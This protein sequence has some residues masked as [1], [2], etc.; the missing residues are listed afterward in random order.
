MNAV[1]S[2]FSIEKDAEITVEMNPESVTE[3]FVSAAKNSGVNRVSLGAQTFSEPIL[4]I[5]SRRHTPKDTENA[6]SLL[7]RKGFENISLDLISAL[8]DCDEDTF[9]SD[10]KKAVMLGADHI[11]AY[12]LILEEGTKL[13]AEREKHRFPDEN[14]CERQ[15]LTVCDYLE[16]SGYSH[17]EISNFAKPE[18][19]SRHNLKYWLL[20]PYLGIGPSAYS[21]FEGRRFHYENDIRKFIRSP[22]TVFD[23]AGGGFEEYIM[24]S[25][26]LK[27]GLLFSELSEYF[28]MAPN[29]RFSETVGLLEKEKLVLSDENGIRLTDKGMLVSNSVIG[30]FLKEELYENL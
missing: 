11:S 16:S 28:G 3:D 21:Y 10:I 6:V 26:R 18:K 2:S 30:E 27:R 25:L 19:E 15:Y 5:L 13:F 29:V 17:Y 7:R 1:F 24:L 12:M 22:E 14:E 20:A 4:K 8:P 9:L 23:E